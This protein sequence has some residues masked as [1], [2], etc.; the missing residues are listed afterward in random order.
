M[1]Q[2]PAQNFQIDPLDALNSEGL[3]EDTREQFEDLVVG[4]QIVWMTLTNPA[5]KAQYD[6]RLDTKTA[7][8]VDQDAIRA[9]SSSNTPARPSRTKTQGPAAPHIE[10][11]TGTH[12]PV[13]ESSGAMSRVHNLFEK[14]KFELAL[15]ILKR[16]RLDNQGDTEV[17]AALGWALWKTRDPKKYKGEA[18][19]YLQMARSFDSRNLKTLEYLARIAMDKGDVTEARKLL[20][21][22]IKLEPSAMWAKQALAS[23]NPADGA[24]S[25]RSKRSWWRG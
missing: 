8:L 12:A 14:G 16:L 7:A 4:L 3:P 2:L 15:P 13:T 24:G 19:E 23:Q 25:S 22:V 18:E 17:L 11:T 20:R 1:Q 21:T 6:K 9:L 5:R 10:A